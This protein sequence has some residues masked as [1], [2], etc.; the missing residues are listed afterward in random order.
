MQRLRRD[1][2]DLRN[3]ID[4]RSCFFFFLKTLGKTAWCLAYRVF[5]NLTRWVWKVLPGDAWTSE[6]FRNPEK[7][8]I[9]QSQRHCRW[10][11]TANIWLGL[12]ASRGYL[13]FNLEVPYEKFQQ[14][15]FKRAMWT[16]AI[17]V[18]IQINWPSLLELDL[19]C[20]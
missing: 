13:K 15:R 5:S 20:K 4:F 2:T 6:Y 7:R 16:I 17:L 3:Y 11:L 8:G 12:L 10:T 18:L 1:K 19:F 9:H 14:S